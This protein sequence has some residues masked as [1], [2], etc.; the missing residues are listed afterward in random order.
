LT[1][2]LLGYLSISNFLTQKSFPTPMR[3]LTSPG[4]RSFLRI[5]PRH[6]T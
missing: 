3:K 1:I 6:F 2:L 4:T 5:S